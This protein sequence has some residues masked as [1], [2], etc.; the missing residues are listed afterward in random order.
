[1]RRATRWHVCLIWRNPVSFERIREL[2][3]QTSL[4]DAHLIGLS[5]MYFDLTR[6]DER[7]S[8]WYRK[9][10][11]ELFRAYPENVVADESK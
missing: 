7:E 5:E 1:M 10:A 6:R 8:D 9:I 4:W 2:V 11:E 3:R